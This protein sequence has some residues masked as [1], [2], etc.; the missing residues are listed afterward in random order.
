MFKNLT[1]KKGFTL[2]ELLIVVAIIGILAAIAIPGYLGAQEKARKSNIVK[3]A[4]SS[5]ADLQHWL[6]SAFKGSV[7]G[8]PGAA[9]IEVDSNWDGTINATDMTNTLL[10]AGGPASTSVVT[11]YIVGRTGGAGMN[12]AERSPW[13]GM[14][15]LPAATLLFATAADVV[16]TTL[17]VANSQGQV[18]F[19]MPSASTIRVRA[20]DNGP[21]G[22]L[23]ASSALL[24][25]TVVSSE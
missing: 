1:N 12:G 4:E 18:L 24:M 13:A 14:G 22:G 16:C 19:S 15:G 25:C 9:L 11:Q 10:F 2:I 23:T 21:G 5:K 6:N 3:A 20:N 7:T 17:T 8:S